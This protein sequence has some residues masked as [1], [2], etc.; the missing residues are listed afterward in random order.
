MSAKLS[1]TS[2][3]RSGRKFSCALR[4]RDLE[5]LN[6]H[7]EELNSSG[8]ESADYQSI[9]SAELM[10]LPTAVLTSAVRIRSANRGGQARRPR[11]Q[12]NSEF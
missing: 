8:D 7:A 12:I 4:L 3:N 11:R 9:W 1:R 10:H 2:P 5:L 6:R